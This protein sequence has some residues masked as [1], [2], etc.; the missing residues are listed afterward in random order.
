MNIQR[1][2]FYRYQHVTGP[3]CVLVSIRFGKTPGTGP[4]VIRLM[5]EGK[6]DSAPS[7]D[8]PNHV[9]EIL[10]GV[11][12]ANRE[13]GGDLEVEAIEVVPDDYPKKT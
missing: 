9:A 10:S 4:T 13:P 5:S 1:S 7:F 2:V 6:R 12:K 3:S 8:V 11:A